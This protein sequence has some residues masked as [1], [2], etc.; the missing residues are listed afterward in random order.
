MG[1]KEFRFQIVSC[2]QKLVAVNSTPPV[3]LNLMGHGGMQWYVSRKSIPPHLPPVDFF[4]MP[5][6]CF[7]SSFQLVQ[8]TSRP[9]SPF[10]VSKDPSSPINRSEAS[11]CFKDFWCTTQDLGM[12]IQMWLIFSNWVRNCQLDSNWTYE[13]NN[14]PDLN[15]LDSSNQWCFF[16]CVLLSVGLVQCKNP[17]Y[18]HG[19]KK[20]P[21][22]LEMREQWSIK[23]SVGWTSHRGWV[24]VLPS[25]IPALLHQPFFQKIPSSTNE[26]FMVHASFWVLFLFHETL[27]HLGCDLYRLSTGIKKFEGS[28]AV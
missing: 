11:D 20:G 2:P 7:W 15:H 18:F 9:K 22:N 25:Q 23:P 10:S 27:A 21:V 26:Y 4:R 8:L 3:F 5:S 19:F 12:M 13:F 14:I 24:V 1:Q 6:F 17:S 28:R 16:L